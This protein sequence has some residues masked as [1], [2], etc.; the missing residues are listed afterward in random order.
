MENNGSVILMKIFKGELY[1][2]VKYSDY[3]LVSNRYD[4]SIDCAYRH[5]G[6]NSVRI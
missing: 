2:H 5:D 3:T 1:C 4:I 6:N